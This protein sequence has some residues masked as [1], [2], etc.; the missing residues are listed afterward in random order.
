[1]ATRELH[2]L[3]LP[4]GFERIP[5]VAKIG[6]GDSPKLSRVTEEDLRDVAPSDERLGSG[7]P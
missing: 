7:K 6:L 3:R 1:V 2:P 5:Q 4:E